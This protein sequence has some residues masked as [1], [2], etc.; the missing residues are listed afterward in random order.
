MYFCLNT[1]SGDVTMKGFSINVQLVRE[2]QGAINT[3]KK[4]IDIRQQQ[5]IMIFTIIT[6]QILNKDLF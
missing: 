2:R 5:K 3:L 4:N 1:S 6:E